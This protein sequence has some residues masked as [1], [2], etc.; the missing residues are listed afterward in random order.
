MFGL[1]LTAPQVPIYNKQ[2]E[3]NYS[4]YGLSFWLLKLI[5]KGLIWNFVFCHIYSNCG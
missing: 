3:R 4:A 2:R 1:V 5:E